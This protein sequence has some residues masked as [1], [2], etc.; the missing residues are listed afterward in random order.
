MQVIASKRARDEYRK[1]IRMIEAAKAGKL[2]S[3]E[4]QTLPTEPQGLAALLL[5]LHLLLT[6]K[7][8][9]SIFVNFSN[10]ERTVQKSSL[11]YGGGVGE[12]SI[13]FS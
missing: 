3:P 4:G 8:P 1:A 10:H 7:K 5:L 9:R 6:E 11:W 12:H 13:L 2:I